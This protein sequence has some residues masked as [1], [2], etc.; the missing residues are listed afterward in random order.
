MAASRA[1]LNTGELGSSGVLPGLVLGPPPDIPQEGG[2][3]GRR[4]VEPILG[5]AHLLTFPQPWCPSRAAMW[6]PPAPRVF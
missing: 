3:A 5:E 4:E 2:G 1:V 6:S